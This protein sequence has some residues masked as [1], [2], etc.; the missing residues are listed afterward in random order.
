MLQNT[1]K[2]AKNFPHFVKRGKIKLL[3]GFFSRSQDAGENVE[4][5][6]DADK[7]IGKV[8]VRPREAL[9]MDLYEVDDVSLNYPVVDVSDGPRKYHGDTDDQDS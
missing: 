2:G 3:L 1:S 7:N 8:E 6:A 4:P 5:Y 9:V